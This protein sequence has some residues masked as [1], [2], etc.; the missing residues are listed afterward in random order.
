MDFI[1]TPKQTCFIVCLIFI[2]YDAQLKSLKLKNI[3]IKYMYFKTKKLKC[4]DRKPPP[5]EFHTRAQNKPLKRSY[6]LFLSFFVCV[7]E[8]CLKG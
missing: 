6:F 8:I 7:E 3:R 4:I 1:L 5:T 2:L